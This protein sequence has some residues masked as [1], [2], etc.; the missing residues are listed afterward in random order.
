MVRGVRRLSLLSAFAATV[1]AVPGAGP[2]VAR[3]AQAADTEVPAPWALISVSHDQRTLFVRY[4]SG[5]C[6]HGGHATVSET[7]ATITVTVSQFTQT[8][9][10]VCPALVSFPLLAVP[11]SAPVA[12]RRLQGNECRANTNPG[13]PPAGPLEVFHGS[14][15]L[16]KV[17]RLIGLSPADA[18]AALRRQLFHTRVSGHGPVVVAER[19]AP[20]TLLGQQ[21]RRPVVI[22]AGRL[23]AAGHA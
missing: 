2:A 6:D 21:D 13:C 18:R 22:V 11:L 10:V 20:T 17:P 4:Q 8:G 15:V 7:P 5:G 12:G 1:V 14:D 19:P 9:N 23:P 3:V 16:R